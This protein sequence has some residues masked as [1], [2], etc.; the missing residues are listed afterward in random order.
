MRTG[1]EK[2]ETWCTKIK[3]NV[4]LTNSRRIKPCENLKLDETLLI[5]YSIM[6][7]LVSTMLAILQDKA[8]DL[9]K[10][11][12]GNQQFSAYLRQLDRW[13]R[14]HGARQIGI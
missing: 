11:I 12:F 2:I 8:E 14:R 9:N 1:R 7:N 5:V 4:G 10:V 6:S 3:S 13:K